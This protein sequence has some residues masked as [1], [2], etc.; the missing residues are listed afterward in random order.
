MNNFL[1]IC[2]F[3]GSNPGSL[4]AYRQAAGEL[5]RLLVQQGVGI[6]YG[7]GATGIMGSLADA[8]LA[9]G[10][11]VIGVLPEA[12]N[13]PGVPHPRLTALHVVDSMHTRKA[14]M[15][16]LS[17][18]FIA[19]PGGVGTFDELFETL[20]WSQLGYQTKPIGIL[21]VQRYFDPLV[22]MIDHAVAHG[23]VKPQHRQ[24]FAVATEPALLLA[25]L[26]DY[27]HPAGSKWT[28]LDPD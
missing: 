25:A 11:Q 14:T 8:A 27:R 10:G 4:E 7:G 15:A 23:F 6:V 17:D 9:A 22:E 13:R 1:R 24:L 3:C 12:M 5:G 19:L 21:N 16:Q 2:V 28:E 26:R 18:A 20:T